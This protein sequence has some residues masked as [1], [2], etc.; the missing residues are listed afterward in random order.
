LN[1]EELNEVEIAGDVNNK[2]HLPQPQQQPQQKTSHQQKESTAASVLAAMKG[3]H[4]FIQL[5]IGN[6]FFFFSILLFT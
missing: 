6:L 5:L 2:Q 4:P 3:Q 1:S